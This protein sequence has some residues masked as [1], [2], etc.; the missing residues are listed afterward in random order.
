LEVPVRDVH[1]IADE[2]VAVHLAAAINVRP[3]PGEDQ[4]A[5][6]RIAIEHRLAS[7]LCG[8]RGD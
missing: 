3:N 2:R 1:I 7:E 5:A 4:W 8:Y 6:K